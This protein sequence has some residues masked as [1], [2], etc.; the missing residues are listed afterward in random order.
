M[1][2]D[3]AVVTG[4]PEVIGAGRAHTR[5]AGSD[6]PYRLLIGSIAAVAAVA[7]ILFFYAIISQS[8]PG[9]RVV[10]WHFFYGSNWNYGAQQYGALPLIVGTLLTAGVAVLLAAPTGV[11]AAVA[12]AFLIPKRARLVISSLVE[13][14]AFVPSII[15]GAWGYLLIQPWLDV[16]VQPW[17]VRVFHH[18]FPFNQNGIGFGLLLGSMVLAVMILPTITAISR[19]VLVSV[20]D[21][22]I[23]GGLSVG[24][25]RGQVLRRVVLPSA[26]SGIFGAIVLGTG[27]ALGE[28]IALVLLL[29]GLDL[30]HPY[31]QGLN[32]GGA[33][34]ATE[35]AQNLGNVT[36]AAGLGILCCL[37]LVLMVIVGL[38]NL[39][40]RVI[41]RRNL[42]KLTA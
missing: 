1:S 6:L 18:N 3:T 39:S 40:A 27:R 29:G 5:S 13:I 38:V 36:G 8:V 30:N 24:A 35:I 4:E 2:I 41:V 16:T 21:E 42:R 26:R 12:I 10:G 15:Y 14:L 17:L 33:T 31:P 23:E 20:P 19:D 34:L 22:L 32:S 7:I 11:A 28:T 25:S 9:W 37:A